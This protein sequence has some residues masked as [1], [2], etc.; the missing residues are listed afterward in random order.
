MAGVAGG[1]MGDVLRRAG[2]VFVDNRQIGVGPIQL[3]HPLRH[4]P[5]QIAM[6]MHSEG[7]SRH[8]AG[9]WVQGD[10]AVGVAM[11]CRR[12][13]RADPDANAK[14][15]PEFTAQ[16]LFGRFAGF[17]L[18]PGEFPFEGQRHGRAPLGRQHGSFLFDDGTGH[19]EM[20]L[21]GAVVC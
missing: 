18:S 12:E 2:H 7:A 21:H 9:E 10:G 17:D 13:C 20:A 16:A 19:V 15:L 6:F 8:P 5:F 3:P 1:V 11:G 4:Y 14:F